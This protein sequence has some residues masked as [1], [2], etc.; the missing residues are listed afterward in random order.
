MSLTQEANT[1]RLV[2]YLSPESIYVKRIHSWPSVCLG[3]RLSVSR[4]K[5]SRGPHCRSPDCIPSELM[6]QAQPAPSPQ[7]AHSLETLTLHLS[8]SCQRCLFFIA[9]GEAHLRIL[10]PSSVQTQYLPNELRKSGSQTV[11]TCWTHTETTH[12]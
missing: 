10:P 8:F 9:P 6:M 11:H 1:P 2:C 5:S 12:L 7:P 3:L 4:T